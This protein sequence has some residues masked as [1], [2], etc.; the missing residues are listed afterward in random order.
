MNDEWS[1][2]EV[3]M[4]LS[5]QMDLINRIETELPVESWIVDGIHIWPLVRII[6]EVVFV[7]LKPKIQVTSRDTSFKKFLN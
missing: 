4:N 5:K 7:L 3:N 1:N 6:L 2:M